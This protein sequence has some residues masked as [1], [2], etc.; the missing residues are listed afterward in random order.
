MSLTKVL[1]A[2]MLILGISYAG[3][4][5]PAV[6]SP[7]YIVIIKKGHRKPHKRRH[8]HH[9]HHKKST[10]VGTLKVTHKN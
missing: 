5:A 6:A 7:T 3:V 8:R 9:K 2:V 4:S 1:L 10:V